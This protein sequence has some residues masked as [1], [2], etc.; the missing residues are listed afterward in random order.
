MS[1]TTLEFRATMTFEDGET[2]THSIPDVSNDNT[3]I[4]NIVPRVQAINAGTAA[5]VDALRRTF[6]ST[7]GASFVSISGAR[8]IRTTEEEIYSG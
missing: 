6:V 1:K 2:I 4:S 5:N 8:L 3:T 7:A